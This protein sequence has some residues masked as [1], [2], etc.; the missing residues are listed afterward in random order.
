MRVVVWVE[1][2]RCFCLRR[3]D[4]YPLV[5][6]CDDGDS[7]FHFYSFLH[8]LIFL[9]TIQSILNMSNISLLAQI[10]VRA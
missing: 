10:N 1:C 9:V 2:F 4:R 3:K 8:P 6:V 5:V 7:R